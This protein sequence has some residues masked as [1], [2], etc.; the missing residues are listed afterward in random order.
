M[1]DDLQQLLIPQHHSDRL[2][3]SNLEVVMG[4]IVYD[5]I[6]DNITLFFKCVAKTTAKVFHTT[7]MSC[8]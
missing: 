6:G 8:V 5:S 4:R 1:P 3:L 2:I 7:K